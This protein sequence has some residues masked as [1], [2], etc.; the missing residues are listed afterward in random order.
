MRYGVLFLLHYALI[1]PSL[2]AQDAPRTLHAR[3]ITEPITIDGLL[4]EEV[5]SR[6]DVA[7][8][9][10][11]Y[12][13]SDSVRAQHPTETRVLYD[14]TTL[15]VS[16]R[17]AAPNPDYVVAT[18][19]RDFGG[20]T[21]DNVSLLFDTFNDGTNAYFFGVTPYG[22]QRE[23][24]VSEGGRTFNNTWDV[25]WQAEARRYDDHYTVEIAIPFTSLKFEEGATRWGFRPYRWNLQ[26][27]EQSTWVRVPQNQQLS[28]LAFMGELVFE[29]PLGKSRTPFALIPYVNALTQKD[30][31]LDRSDQDLQFGG[32]A[33]VAIG[34]GMNL[35]LTVNPDFSNVEVDDI[36]TDL[37]R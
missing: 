31:T 27:N 21:N 36:F 29:K 3:F 24:L 19:K 37:T 13:P 26:T 25:K 16:F 2:R 23:G 33:K 32:D 10:W 15:Y 12:F 11:Q 14:A 7:G 9:F 22:V 6:A 35:D 4:D 8:D 17:A 28:S 1:S 5:W 18:L 34:N 30:F 20:T